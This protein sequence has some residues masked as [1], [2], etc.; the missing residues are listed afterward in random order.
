[1]T[2]K[3]LDKWMMRN[4]PNIY[5][6][7]GGVTLSG[8]LAK[9]AQ[10]GRTSLEDE[11]DLARALAIRSTALYGA[12][13]DAGDNI[14]E[15]TKTALSVLVEKSIDA[16]SRTATAH[17]R[18]QAWEEGTI[19]LTSVQWILAEITKIIDQEIRTIDDS[20]ADKVI[21][22]MK[23]IKV[24]NDKNVKSFL[25]FSGNREEFL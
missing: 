23:D 9:V 24:P 7:N 1:M 21:E 22:R 2:S 15:D 3:N 18:I 14:D 25:E 6:K 16:V 5:L 11:I 8:I 19:Q 10:A 12:A 17:A 4:D 20:V 13:L